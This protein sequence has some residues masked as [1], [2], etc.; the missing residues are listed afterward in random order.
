MVVNS[1]QLMALIAAYLEGRGEEIAPDTRLAIEIDTIR[2]RTLRGDE[3]D[4]EG[5]AP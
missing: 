3:G 5:G 1:P 2:V 4:S